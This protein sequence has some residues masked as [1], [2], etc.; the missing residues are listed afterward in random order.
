VI[1]VDRTCKTPSQYEELQGKLDST[2][3]STMIGVEY[4]TGQYKV[5]QAMD[6][7]EPLQKYRLQ[8]V[9]TEEETMSEETESMHKGAGAER[10]P[11][12]QEHREAFYSGESEGEEGICSSIDEELLERSLH[13]SGGRP[14]QVFTQEDHI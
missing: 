9:M 7:R 3:V 12:E 14:S 13:P 5:G 4:L 10:D 2:K 1:Y 6:E 11:E 8:P